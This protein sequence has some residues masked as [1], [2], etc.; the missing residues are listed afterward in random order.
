ML[1]LRVT[2]AAADGAANAAVVALLAKALGR[3]RSALR[4][5]RG[6]AARVK[7]IEI[8]GLDEAEAWRRLG[9]PDG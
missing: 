5:L 6:D 3:P 8:D 4:I 9:A 7:Q 1:K 2:P